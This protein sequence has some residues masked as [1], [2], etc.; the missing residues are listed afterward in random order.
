MKLLP[1][2]LAVS[3]SL[4]S[5]LCRHPGRRAKCSE[6]A[7]LR[8]AWSFTKTLPARI[9]SICTNNSA[10]DHPRLRRSRQGVPRIPRLYADRPGHEYSR[11]R[12]LTRRPRPASA[13]TRRR[14]RSVQGSSQL[15]A[16][17]PG[18]AQ[19]FRAFTPEEQKKIQAL[20]KDPSIATEVQNDIDAGNMVPVQKTPTMV[21]I[22]KARSSLGRLDQLSAVQELFGWLLAGK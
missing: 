2:P 21:M 17:R 18:L 4:L 14:R 6:P 7:P 19:H 8:C 20:V 11:T 13:N 15:G 5:P 3:V 16:E 10:D 1:S 22:T 12:P 9:A